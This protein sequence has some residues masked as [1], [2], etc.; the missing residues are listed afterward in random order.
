[1]SSKFRFRLHDSV[2]VAD[3]EQD[4]SFLK[5]CFMDVGDTTILHD[6]DDP[7]RIVLGRTGAGKTALLYQ[8]SEQHRDN[9]IEVK[10]ESLALAYISNSTIL[11]FVHDLGVNLNIFI[12]ASLAS[13]LYCRD[14]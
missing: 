1:M 14:S 13:R 5:K 9:V 11:Q 7:R 10:P 12:Q 3:A 8:F 2:G 6:C 4:H